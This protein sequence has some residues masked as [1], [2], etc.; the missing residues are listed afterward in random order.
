VVGVLE[1]AVLVGLVVA[2]WRDRAAPVRR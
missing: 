1:L 2:R